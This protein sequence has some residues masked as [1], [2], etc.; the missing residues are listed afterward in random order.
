MAASNKNLVKKIN[1][2]LPVENEK[3]INKPAKRVLI[4]RAI[5]KK[6]RI[7]VV[8]KGLEKSDPI[9]KTVAKNNFVTAVHSVACGMASQKRSVKKIA[10][11]KDENIK[12]NEVKK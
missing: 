9:K 8:K 3:A 7:E 11:V 2:I 12:R 6:T 1:P 4:K 10:L 5:L